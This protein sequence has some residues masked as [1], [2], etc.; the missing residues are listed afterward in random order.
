MV[1]ARGKAAAAGLRKGDIVISVNR[2]RVKTIK[3]M[4]AAIKK[5]PEALLLNIQRASR[6]LF[7]LIR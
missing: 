7:I 6:G 4:K 5:N 3:D 1:Q 2:E